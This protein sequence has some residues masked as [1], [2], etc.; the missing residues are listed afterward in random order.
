MGWS[1]RDNFANGDAQPFAALWSHADDVTLFGGFGAGQLGWSEVATRIDFAAARFRS[2]ELTYE[3]MSSSTSGDLGYAVG[4]ERGR[5]TV[6]GQ[7]EPGELVLRV[8]HLFRREDGEWK[9]IHRHADPLSTVTA[10][11]DLLQARQ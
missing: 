9:I 2:G 8:T 6:V 3:P 5:A 7:D 10:P 4:I 11:G 1:D